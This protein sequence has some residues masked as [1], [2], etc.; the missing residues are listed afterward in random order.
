MAHQNAGDQGK[1]SIHIGKKDADRATELG[2]ENES[3]STVYSD[4]LE[5]WQRYSKIKRKERREAKSK[6]VETV[7]RM[8]DRHDIDRNDLLEDIVDGEIV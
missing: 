4:A 1:P 6:I 8:E 3:P 5:I 2:V 7:K